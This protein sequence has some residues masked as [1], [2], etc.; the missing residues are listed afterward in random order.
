MYV[1]WWKGPAFVRVNPDLDCFKL[2]VG[3]HAPHSSLFSLVK[4]ANHAAFPYTVASNMK[5]T[6]GDRCYLSSL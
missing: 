6:L 2:H 5:R 1:Q 3:S 4:F